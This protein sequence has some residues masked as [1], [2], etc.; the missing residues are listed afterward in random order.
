MAAD[1]PGVWGGVG[2]WAGGGVRRQEALWGTL[3]GS[4]CRDAIS[5]AH[6]AFNPHFKSKSMIPLGLCT[7][8]W[9]SCLSFPGPQGFLKALCCK[10]GRGFT[11]FCA[12]W[13][14]WYMICCTWGIVYVVLCLCFSSGPESVAASSAVHAGGCQRERGDHGRGEWG[15]HGDQVTPPHSAS[16]GVCGCVGWGRS[17][18]R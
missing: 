17:E 13:L 15:W 11:V 18:E 5:A 2:A 9:P 14:I 16:L 6:S 8:L 4:V 1:W 10:T 3:C 7:Q 12:R